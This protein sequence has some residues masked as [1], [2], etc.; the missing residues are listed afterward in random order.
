V[1]KRL[2]VIAL[3]AVL[4]LSM[5]VSPTFAETV[6]EDY[7]YE[8]D[9]DNSKLTYDLSEGKNA[10]YVIIDAPLSEFSKLNAISPLDYEAVEA[11]KT[12]Y[13]TSGDS[14]STK[15]TFKSEYLN[16]LPSDEYDFEAVFTHENGEEDEEETAEFTVYVYSYE[17]LIDE[18]NS[19]LIYNPAG[20]LTNVYILVDAPQR[21]FLKVVDENEK[22]I[23]VTVSDEKIMGRIGIRITFHK[24]YLAKLKDGFNFFDVLFKDKDESIDYSCIYVPF[25]FSAA[26]VSIAFSGAVWT[27]RQIKPAVKK[28]EVDNE[29]L[30]KNDYTITYGANKNIGKGT[31][32]ITPKKNSLEYRGEKTVSFDILPQKPAISKL[33][34]GKNQIKVAWAKAPAA[35]KITKYELRYKAK[36]SGKWITKSFPAKTT[37]T[38]I[39]KLKKNKTYQF[40]L[41]T[42]RTVGGK[43]YSS[44]WS[45]VKTGKTVK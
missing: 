5:S 16:T 26:N 40:Q 10:V 43:K 22:K 24:E 42:C 44:A 20:K 7:T 45:A 15:I 33:T 23:D 39:K 32:T 13:G 19:Q 6:E 14:T 36:G 30:G 3:A 8:V 18:E 28:V 34:A 9:E 37:N 31:V 38:I 41:R 4:A 27:G 11:P 12:N 35:Q 17:Y 29:K 2:L 1:R 21:D 25:N